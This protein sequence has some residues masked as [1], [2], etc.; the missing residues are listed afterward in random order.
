MLT[1]CIFFFG[2]LG[3]EKKTGTLT[4]EFLS[5]FDKSYDI[6]LGRTST[7]F[8]SPDITLN[9]IKDRELLYTKGRKEYLLNDF[10]IF[11]FIFTF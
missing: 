4:F 7:N 1:I 11:N 5:D 8:V 6:K 3:R 9:C 2:F 10:N